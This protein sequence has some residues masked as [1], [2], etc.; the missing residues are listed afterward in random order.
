MSSQSGVWL[1]VSIFLKSNQISTQEDIDES[2]ITLTNL[3]KT[4]FCDGFMYFKKRKKNSVN[5]LKIIQLPKTC[6]N[7]FRFSDFP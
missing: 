3:Y 2:T 7:A 4:K 1:C 6:L 5:I